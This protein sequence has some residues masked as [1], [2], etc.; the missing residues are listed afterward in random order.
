MNFLEWL[1]LKK[2]AEDLDPSNVIKF[3]EPKAVPAMPEVKPPAEKPANV[4]YRLGLTDNNR[5]AFSMGYSEI[6][7]NEQGIQNLID[8]LEFFKN[9]LQ[10]SNV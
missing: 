9:Q 7:M 5:L 1:G 10:D 4:F 8:Q 3:P 6:T 2:V